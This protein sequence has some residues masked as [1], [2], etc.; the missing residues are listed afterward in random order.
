MTPAPLPSTRAAGLARLAAF[1]PKAGRAYASARNTDP[2]PGQPTGVSG[3]S[4]YVRHRL[5]TEWEVARAVLDQ[6]DLRTAEKFIQ[7]VCWRTYWK[8]WLEQRPV[9]WQRYLDDLAK[10]RDDLRTDTALAADIAAAEAGT[11]GIACFDAWARELVETGTLHNHTRMW[12]ASLWIFTLKLPWQFGADFF[13]RHLIDGD[14]ASN[15][16]SWRWVGGLHTAGK[17]YLARPDNIATYTNGRF[18]PRTDE[19]AAHAPPLDE[20]DPPTERMPLPPGDAVAPGTPVVRLV[21]LEDLAPELWPTG[22]LDIRATAFA[23]FAAAGPAVSPVVATFR[24]GAFADA[25]ER[26]QAEN[27]GPLATLDSAEALI[28]LAHSVGATSIATPQLPVGWIRPEV[29]RWA[30]DLAAAGLPLK[31]LAHPWDAHF[32]PHAKAGFFGLKDKIPGTLRKLGLET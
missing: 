22:G 27:H 17:T 3:L 7:E 12:F 30:V 5:V 29:E 13:L 20:D 4:P 25:A 11:T 16:L 1:V 31:Q 9:V 26:L 15:T 14:P 19:L 8:G 21:T 6:H 18:R 2:G 24:A 23:P 28:E 32:W 10:L